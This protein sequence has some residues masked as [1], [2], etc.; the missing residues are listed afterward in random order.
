MKRFP[1]LLLALPL[2]GQPSL[3][4]VPVPRP[5]NLEGVVRDSAALTVLGKALFW[6]RQA[7]SDGS[8]ACATCHFHAGADHR[9]QHQYTNP[10]FRY[11]ANAILTAEDFPFRLLSDPAN[12]GSAVRR[13][14][15]GVYGSAGIFRRQSTGAAADGSAASAGGSVTTGARCTPG[16]ARVVAYAVGSGASSSSRSCTKLGRDP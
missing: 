7:G 11:D 1:L 9:S 4:T 6:D 14:N 15:T 2:L 13:E 12:N 5:A 3:R 10:H 8:T 16:P